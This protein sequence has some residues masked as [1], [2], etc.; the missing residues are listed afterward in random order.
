V[1]IDAFGMSTAD[2]AQK[3]LYRDNNHMVAHFNK[4]VADMIVVEACN[5]DTAAVAK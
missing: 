5:E 2:L 1:V 3:H 4:A